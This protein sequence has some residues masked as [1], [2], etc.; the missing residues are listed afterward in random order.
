M[1][2]GCI[3]ALP[4]IGRD[5][6]TDRAVRD[7]VSGPCSRVRA[8]FAGSLVRRLSAGHDAAASA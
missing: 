6:G 3:V 5:C 8:E 1:T 2:S 4:E 7:R